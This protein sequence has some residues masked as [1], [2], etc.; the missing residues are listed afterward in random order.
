MARDLAAVGLIV[1]ILC[2]N[3]YLLAA[4]LTSDRALTMPPFL[5]G[6]MSIREQQAAS[7]PEEIGRLAVVVVLMVAPLVASAGLAQRM[8]SK[9]SLPWGG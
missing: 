3:E 7:D 1:F 9:S 4:F 6:Q 8:L 2:W 5:V